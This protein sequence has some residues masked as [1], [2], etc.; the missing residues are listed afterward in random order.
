MVSRLGGSVF[1]GE[2]DHQ[3]NMTH[4]RPIMVDS[5]GFDG[6]DKFSVPSCTSLLF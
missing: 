6:L 4:P 3:Q 5:V 2:T 1:G